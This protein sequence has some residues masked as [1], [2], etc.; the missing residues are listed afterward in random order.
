MTTLQT[1]SANGAQSLD[2]GGQRGRR[3]G[4]LANAKVMIRI[5]LLF[6]VLF[7]LWNRRYVRHKRSAKDVA[8]TKTKCF[9]VSAAIVSF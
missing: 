9:K 8:R 5:L 2:D 7:F 3:D 6:N 1:Y 4:E